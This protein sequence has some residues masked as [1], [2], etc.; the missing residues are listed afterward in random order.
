MLA[1]NIKNIDIGEIHP[2]AGNLDKDVDGEEKGQGLYRDVRTYVPRL[3]Q[4]YLRVNKSR[5]DKLL[6]FDDAKFQKLDAS[7]TLFLLSVGGDEAPLSGTTF[8]LSFINVGRRICSSYNNFLIFG[9]NVKENGE[10]VRRYLKKFHDDI[11]YL[12]SKVFE[13][14]VDGNSIKVEFQLELVPNDMKMMC[15]ISGKLS[16]AAFYFSSF[17]NVT[18]ENCYD[19]LRR[20]NGNHKKDWQPFPYQKRLED[21]KHVVKKK[22]QLS[23]KCLKQETMRNNITSFI[24]TLQS[25]Q[26]F[27]PPLGKYIN[28]GKAEPLH[29]KNNVCKE[30]F[31]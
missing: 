4:F 13:V 30:I 29:L 22:H 21:V 9:V 24:R 25:R 6:C 19:F 12:E 27:V 11:R 26:E 7:S 14:N 2:I 8:L 3:A 1:K 15:F 28:A 17:A 23:F 5:I 16:N 31:F 20:F 18:K 10:V